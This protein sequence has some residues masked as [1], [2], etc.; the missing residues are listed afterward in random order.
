[1]EPITL[2]DILA[3]IG[4]GTIGWFGGKAVGHLHDWIVELWEKE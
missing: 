2:T 4:L 3:I 1:M